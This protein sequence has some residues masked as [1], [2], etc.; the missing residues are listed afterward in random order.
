MVQIG[1]K[2]Y[3]G[4]KIIEL[5][6]AAICSKDPGNFLGNPDLTKRDIQEVVMYNAEP[7]SN[8]ESTKI[9]ITI[10]DSTYAKADLD[11]V[12]TDSF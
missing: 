6:Y 3:F 4:R 1:L 10:I 9:V 7:E 5:D 11:K 12:A 2:A 8:R